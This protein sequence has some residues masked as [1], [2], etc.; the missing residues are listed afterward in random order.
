MY[1]LETDRKSATNNLN[2]PCI[3]SENL[4]PVD[5]WCRFD[6]STKQFVPDKNGCFSAHFNGG[7][8]INGE[9]YQSYSL[10]MIIGSGSVRYIVFTN[11]N[12]LKKHQNRQN[13]SWMK[14]L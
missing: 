8:D 2:G 14:F 7:Y 4:P 1:Y 12:D 9:L 5:V 13:M 6:E 3:M 11:E 10:A